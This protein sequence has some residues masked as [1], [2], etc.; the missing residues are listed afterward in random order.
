VRDRQDIQLFQVEPCIRDRVR[1]HIGFGPQG[2][3]LVP[4][5][6]NIPVQAWS[7]PG[8]SGNGNDQGA[9]QGEPL[10]GPVMPLVRGAGL[11]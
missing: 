1:G 6:Y 9:L 8:G 2:L 7:S 4:G 5:K 11:D 3:R 10:S